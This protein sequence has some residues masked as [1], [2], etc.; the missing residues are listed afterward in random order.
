MLRQEK[1]QTS[2]VTESTEA[3]ETKE[4]QKI[5]TGTETGT[6][7][8]KI[9]I[10]EMDTGLLPG[11]TEATNLA[12]IE[13]NVITGLPG[14]ETGQGK[15]QETATETIPEVQMHTNAPGLKNFYPGLFCKGMQLFCCPGSRL[16]C[17]L[18]Q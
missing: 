14:I 8:E 3:A 13:K 5:D 18:C 2:V 9:L 6:E 1:L 11:T 12:G 7:V 15:I 10:E 4:A 17:N 16:C